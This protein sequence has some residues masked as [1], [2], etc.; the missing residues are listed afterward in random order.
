MSGRGPLMGRAAAQRVYAPSIE[1]S[2]VHWIAAASVGAR[3][4]LL[5]S[6]MACQEALRREE[7]KRRIMWTLAL[8]STLN[9]HV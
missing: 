1:G 3:T 7:D 9:Q 5:L 2:F 4:R 6:G 8:L